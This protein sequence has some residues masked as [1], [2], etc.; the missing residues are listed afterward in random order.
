MHPDQV[1]RYN[2]TRIQIEIVGFS[3]EHRSSKYPNIDFH[4][5]FSL[6]SRYF[7]ISEK[8]LAVRMYRI[9]VPASNTYR[10]R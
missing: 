1:H 8:T 6:H 2:F 9:F 3:G 4:A 10:S 7:G 5:R